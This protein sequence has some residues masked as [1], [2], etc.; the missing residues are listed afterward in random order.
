MPLRPACLLLVCSCAQAV[1]LL[2]DHIPTESESPDFTLVLISVLTV[3]LC[4][5]CSSFCVRVARDSQT[6]LTLLEKRNS[7]ARQMVLATAATATA[8]EV[9]TTIK[10]AQKSSE[11]DFTSE[12]AASYVGDL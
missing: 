7:H 9:T 6:A 10:F 11:G 8:T 3:C 2:P 4:C 12:S 1:L 5:T